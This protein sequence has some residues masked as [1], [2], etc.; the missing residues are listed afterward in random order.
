M[1]ALFGSQLRFHTM[2]SIQNNRGLEIIPFLTMMF[3]TK[4]ASVLPKIPTNY[5]SQ[6][7]HLLAEHF[8]RAAGY[9]AT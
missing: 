4:A 3:A 2:S 1:L 6:C 8:K 7:I 5:Y 9:S